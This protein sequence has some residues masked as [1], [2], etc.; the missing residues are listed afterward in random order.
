MERRGFL[1]VA[2]VVAFAMLLLSGLFG[3]PPPIGGPAAY[4]YCRGALNETLPD[5]AAPRFSALW[6][7]AIEPSGH[8]WHVTGYVIA[9]DGGGGRSRM[10]YTCIVHNDGLWWHLDAL[11]TG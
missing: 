10:P 2:G 6:E 11:R 1:L 5:N 3:A 8:G 4:L 9:R 7:S